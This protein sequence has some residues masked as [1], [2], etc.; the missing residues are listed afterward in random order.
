MMAKA[1]DEALVI[2]QE[3]WAG[4]TSFLQLAKHTNEML[5][6]SIK[7]RKAHLMSGLMAT[8]VQLATSD[9]EADSGFLE[10]VKG[11]LNNFKDKLTADY[12]EAAAT[13]D[14]SVAAYNADKSRLEATIENLTQQ[15]A[16]LENEINELNKCI[17]TQQGIISSATA[18]KDRNQRLLDD[19]TALCTAVDAEY[20]NATEA[21][22]EELELLGA[23][24]ERVEARFA[25]LSK[26]VTERGQQDNFT[27]EN[28]SDYDHQE[29]VPSTA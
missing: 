5:K 26:G 17:V 14:A 13:E 21:R 15:E 6:T 16:G 2:L 24:R 3:I 12:Q 11:E 4:E 7:I 19:A 18:K 9:I 28:A 29:F 23:I 20:K 25:Q 27:Y 8:L 1:L 22:K 10:R